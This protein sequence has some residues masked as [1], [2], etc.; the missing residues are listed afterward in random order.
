MY[1]NKADADA[2]RRK[3]NSEN[4]DRMREYFKNYREQNREKIRMWDRDFKEREKGRLKKERHERYVNNKERHA[5]YG[6]NNR[7]RLKRTVI[8]SLGGHCFCC[9]ENDIGFLTVEHLLK[10]GSQHRREVNGRVY[11]DILKQGS[12]RDKYAVLCMNCNF[13]HVLTRNVLIRKY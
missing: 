13:P 4:K 10:D 1:R 11:S 8:D 7:Q 2:Y 12:P 9:G 3:W 5:E 6:A